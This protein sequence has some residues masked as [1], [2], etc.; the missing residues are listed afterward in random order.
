MFAARL[1]NLDP[2]GNRQRG[3]LWMRNRQ[4]RVVHTEIVGPSLIGWVGVEIAVT[5]H[6]LDG[7]WKTEGC[8]GKRYDGSMTWKVCGRCVG[9]GGRNGLSS[10]EGSVAVTGYSRVVYNGLVGPC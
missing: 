9:E 4:D 5:M 2:Q 1:L 3:L 6:K 8:G 7:R 10:R